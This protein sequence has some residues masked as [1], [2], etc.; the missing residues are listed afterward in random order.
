MLC[1]IFK[2]TRLPVRGNDK[3]NNSA[4]QERKFVKVRCLICEDSTF[5]LIEWMQNAAEEISPK[6]NPVTA[7]EIEK[8]KCNVIHNL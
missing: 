2:S 1:R 8:C 6:I 3:C 7:A 5:F 4:E